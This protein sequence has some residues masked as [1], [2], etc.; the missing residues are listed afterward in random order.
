[1]LDLYDFDRSKITEVLE[2]KG[3]ILKNIGKF[4]EAK[5]LIEDVLSI[6]K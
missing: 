1:M 6:K 4:E 3:V 5:V 2:N